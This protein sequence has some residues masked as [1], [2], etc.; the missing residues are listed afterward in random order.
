MSV[1]DD[2]I[3]SEIKKILILLE[4][5]CKSFHVDEEDKVQQQDEKKHANR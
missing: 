4:K 3:E 5:H 2:F 1:P